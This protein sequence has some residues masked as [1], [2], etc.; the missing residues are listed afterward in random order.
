M[1]ISCTGVYCF[2]HDNISLHRM[3]TGDIIPPHPT[4]RRDWSRRAMTRRE[5]YRNSGLGATFFALFY[6]LVLS[7]SLGDGAS[8]NPPL[9]SCLTMGV[10]FL[11]SS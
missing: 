8:N 2:I 1:I 4:A 9:S 7:E 10:G 11:L 5:V 6:L 3:I